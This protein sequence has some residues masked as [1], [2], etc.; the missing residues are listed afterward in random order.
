MTKTHKIILWIVVV[1]IVIILGNLILNKNN[2]VDE[3]KKPV[4]IGANLALTGSLAFIGTAENN[5][6]LLAVEDVNASGGINGHRLEL[7]TEDNGGD[8]TN[9]ISGMQKLIS[10]DK[11]DLVITAF[12][13][14][15]QAVKSIVAQNNLPMLYIS[16]LPDI[17]S[18]N[19]LFF[20]DY[21]DAVNL[22]NVLGKYMAKT[23]L[24]TFAY[25]G[26]QNDAC[27]PYRDEV[28]RVLESAGKNVTIQEEY[29]STATDLRTQLLKIKTKQV[30]G[31]YTCTW[32]K[33]DIFTNQLNEL[34]MISVPVF[35]TIA[36]FL[37]N[38]DTKEMRGLYEKNKTIST[39][40]G[41]TLGSL[42]D[43]QK[44]F[45]K[46]YEAKFGTK[47]SSD[48]AFAYD[49][50]MVISEALK[51]C[52]STE[53]EID[54][55]CFSEEMLKTNHDGLS[56][57]LSFDKDGISQRE[58]ILIQVNNGEWVEVK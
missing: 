12:T 6:L 33:S 20:R 29:L 52:V 54:N 11:I 13:H 38:A 7:I 36:P 41:F 43:S 55:K 9:A 31:I 40:Y 14:I 28:R 49:D 30:D 57:K 39:W 35:Q 34:G 44:E 2:S 45:A 53:G 51:S 47:L 27:F 3:S 17:A 23:D 32:R 5:G 15:T 1:I 46:R 18:E 4:K 25:L 8:V 10:A 26:E 37:P 16:S 48:A 21:F 19:S 50:I 58:G 24:K 22:G 56:G 42:N